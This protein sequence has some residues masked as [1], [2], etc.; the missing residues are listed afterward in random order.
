MRET[1]A[2]RKIRHLPPE[3][4]PEVPRARSM[5]PGDSHRWVRRAFARAAASYDRVSRVYDE[6]GQRLLAHLDPIAVDPAC[7]LDVGCGTGTGT[8]LLASRYRRALVH[9]VDCA[10][11]MLEVAQSKG[12]EPSSRRRFLCARAERLPVGDRRVD[13]VHANLLL[14]W[15]SVFED[16]LREFAR[17]LA[18]GGLLILS[19][20]GP[21]T[22]IELRR[23]WSGGPVPEAEPGL[24]DM[25]DL[26][27]ALVAAG[28]AGVVMETERLTVQYPSAAGLVDDLVRSG[29]WAAR[30]RRRAG[31]RPR[32]GFAHLRRRYL[33]LRSD[34]P[35]DATVEIV[36]AHAWAP[37]RTSRSATVP[38]PLRVHPGPPRTPPP[39]SEDTP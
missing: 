34:A 3:M 4:V 23:I 5:S 14:P 35:L 37:A 8:V 36:Y 25:H 21:D 28:L 19:S 1:V 26:G 29:A 18:P 11:P 16:P 12:P 39:K 20:L 7:V 13:L 27:D 33:A 22:L 30:A 15:C 9:G 2:S 24:M 10:W 31:G 6:V 32:P 38:A 17:V